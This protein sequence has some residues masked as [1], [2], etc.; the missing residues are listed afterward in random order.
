MRILMVFSE[1]RTGS[2]PFSFSVA[3]QQ[4]KVYWITVDSAARQSGHE[5]DFEWNLS[6]FISA[7]DLKGKTWVAAV[8]WCD[9]IRYSEESPTFASNS[10]HPS[11]LFLTCPKLTQ[12]NTWQSWNGTPSSTICVLPGYVL[13]GFYGIG[14]DQPYVRKKAM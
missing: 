3:L 5:F 14:G 9:V 11:A 7:R 1:F 8:E 10:L 4:M 2:R 12:H 13:T 6:G